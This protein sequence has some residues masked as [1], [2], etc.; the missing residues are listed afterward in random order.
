MPA[1]PLRPE[2]GPVAGDRPTVV[3]GGRVQ[4]GQ[5]GGEPAGVL[6]L[7]VEPGAGVDGERVVAEHMEASDAEQPGLV[8]APGVLAVVDGRQPVGGGPGV[9]DDVDLHLL[10]DPATGRVLG[11][12]QLVV[13]R[14]AG[15]AAEVGRG[16]GRVTF[17]EQLLDRSWVDQVVHADVVQSAV[18]EGQVVRLRH[19]WQWQTGHESSLDGVGEDAGTEDGTEG[20]EVGTEEGTEGVG[21]G[22]RGTVSAAG[23]RSTVRSWWARSALRRARAAMVSEGLEVPSEGIEPQPTA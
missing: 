7:G 1:Q 20:T 4:G 2:R 22:G 15:P 3:H 9:G 11:E 10:G 13:E 12:V 8:V 19:G 21:R 17:G 23:P 18:V 6:G 16:Q 5:D 14:D